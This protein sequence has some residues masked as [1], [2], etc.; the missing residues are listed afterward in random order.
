M[1]WCLQLFFS[2]TFQLLPQLAQMKYSLD[3]LWIKKALPVVIFGKQERLGVCSWADL[4][5]LWTFFLSKDLGSHGHI[6]THDSQFAICWCPRPKLGLWIERW[7]FLLRHPFNC[8]RMNKPGNTNYFFRWYWGSDPRPHTPWANSQP[9]KTTCK[10]SPY[11]IL[12]HPDNNF[13][14]GNNSHLQVRRLRHREVKLLAQD[15]QV[16]I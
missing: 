15:K 9:P 7:H 6:V 14:V 8:Q 4:C 13:W 3:N 11:I 16:A 12:V 10:P 1:F 5:G 2:L